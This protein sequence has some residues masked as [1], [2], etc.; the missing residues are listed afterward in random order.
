M[1]FADCNK[2]KKCLHQKLPTFSTILFNDGGETEN[3]FQ[4]YIHHKKHHNT[5]KKKRKKIHIE[6]AQDKMNLISPKMER[7]RLKS[8]KSL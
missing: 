4:R 6:M 8:M 3:D 7:L 2:T 5:I 1:K